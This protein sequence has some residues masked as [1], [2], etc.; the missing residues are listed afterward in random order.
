[1]PRPLQDIYSVCTAC[2]MNSS[3]DLLGVCSYETGFF[4]TA[5]QYSKSSTLCEIC[6][7]SSVCT[8]CKANAGS[9]L[10]DCRCISDYREETERARNALIL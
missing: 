10:T 4:K 1:M 2:K 6:Y 9:D 5:S 8:K 7:H 3:T